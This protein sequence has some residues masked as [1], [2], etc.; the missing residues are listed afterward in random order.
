MELNEAFKQAAQ[1]FFDNYDFTEI[2]KLD[3]NFKYSF[4]DLDG[5]HQ[6]VTKGRGKSKPLELEEEDPNEVEDDMDEDD[7]E[8]SG[9]A[10]DL[11]YDD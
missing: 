10:A 7:N 11:S 4:S 2:K 6:E 8:D 3:K 9:I 5:I 1:R